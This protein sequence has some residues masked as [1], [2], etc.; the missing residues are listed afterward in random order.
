MPSHRL[1]A[2]RISRFYLIEVAVAWIARLTCCVWIIWRTFNDEPRIEG[3]VRTDQGVWGH[4][5]GSAIHLGTVMCSIGTK[6]QVGVEVND[7]VLHR[8]EVECGTFDSEF[9]KPENRP[10]LV[11]QGC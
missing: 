2:H 8:E 3:A 6:I 11:V 1:D 9:A 10:I 5:G 7:V 4:T